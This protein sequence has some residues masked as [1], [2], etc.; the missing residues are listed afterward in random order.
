MI[1]PL[2]ASGAG[3]GKAN[4]G[5]AIHVEALNVRYGTET[6]LD[7]IDLTVGTGE[8]HALVGRNG[9][10]KS[11]FVRCLAGQQKPQSGTVSVLNQDVWR[12]RSQLA[13][14]IGIVPE[15]PDAPPA[16]D[17]A[18]LSRF[19]RGLYER[20][21]HQGL[22]VRLER[23]GIPPKRP[24]GKLSR[25]QQT[26]VMLALALAHEPEMLVL[27]DPTLGLDAVARRAI[28]EDLAVTLADR[29]IT[30]LLTSHDLPAIEQLATRVTH[31]SKGR[32]LF[33]E[34]LDML[35]S[36]F[37]RLR[38]GP[39]LTRHELAPLEPL[40]VRKHGRDLEA[41]VAHFDATRFVEICQEA[42]TEH[43]ET[44]AMSLEEIVVAT[45]SPTSS[46]TIDLSGETTS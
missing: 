20:R 38:C 37:R 13:A 35:K 5:V 46:W 40:A 45:S 27:D 36:R 18:A 7:G 8:V 24:F 42:G 12:H 21:D 29:G 39:P 11:S 19:C 30:I 25:G 32:F 31:L 22:L 41:I 2:V 26:H 4:A 6:V 34:N 10:G 33:D 43:G 9:A 1:E 23:F 15:T 44:M 14:R 3:S 17:S 16:L 28:L